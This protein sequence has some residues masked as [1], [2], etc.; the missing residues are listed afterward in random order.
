MAPHTRSTSLQR[1]T[2]SPTSESQPVPPPTNIS[3]RPTKMAPPTQHRPERNMA[4][5]LPHCINANTATTKRSRYPPTQ[6]KNTDAHIRRQKSIPCT[7]TPT[8]PSQAPSPSP[9]AS[10]TTPY[11]NHTL[12]TRTTTSTPRHQ[13]QTPVRSRRFSLRRS[14]IKATTSPRSGGT[15]VPPPRGDPTN[16]LPQSPIRR[17]LSE[18]PRPTPHTPVHDNARPTHLAVTPGVLAAGQ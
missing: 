9:P 4:N 2:D 11:P 15:P 13:P 5:Y 10:P 18:P 1:H 3:R 16:L 14:T 17:R 8:A 7:S 12:C 6:A